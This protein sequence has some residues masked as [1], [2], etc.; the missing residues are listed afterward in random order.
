MMFSFRG[1]IMITKLTKLFGK[2]VYTVSGAKVGMVADVAIDVDT[3]K[4]SDLFISNLDPTFQTKYE[5]ED[6]K[7]VVLSYNGV[8]SISDIVLVNTI[9]HRLREAEDEPSV[10][11]EPE[12]D[13]LE[14]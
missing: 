12:Q 5:L 10:L 13:V 4:L 1:D 6:K 7:G 14:E 11:E 2:E 8:R 3:K 9:K